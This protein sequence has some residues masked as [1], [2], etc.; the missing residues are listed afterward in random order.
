[1]LESSF[2]DSNPLPNPLEMVNNENPPLLISQSEHLE[3]LHSQ[4]YDEKH[5]PE[6]EVGEPSLKG[7]P[8][9]L[10]QGT[11][12][13][14]HCKIQQLAT[15]QNENAHM[16]SSVK[17]SSLNGPPTDA[18][19]KLPTVSSGNAPKEEYS[20]RSS[21]FNS[22][23]SSHAPQSHPHNF[24]FSPHNSGKPVEFQIPTPPSPPYYPTN[25]CNCCQ[26]HGHI[27]YSPINPWQELQSEALQKHTLFHP[28][29]RPA[30]CHNAF[31]SSS[32]PIALRPQGSMDGCSPHG[33]V[34]PSPVARLPSHVDSYNRPCAV[35][36]HTPNNESDNGMMGLSPDAYRFLT[37]QNRQLRL[38]QAQV[39]WELS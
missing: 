29:G 8:N 6:A 31:C 10:S 27:R 28:S 17:P 21:T 15:C 9:Q 22:R 18:S 20:V 25:V 3:P 37:E 35:C 33:N 1:M 32:S 39:C 16:R 34:E 26:H 36:M 12:P 7:L 23:Q 2:T 14:G 19:E 30:L 13:L 24:T 38:L 4:L 5:S 11:T